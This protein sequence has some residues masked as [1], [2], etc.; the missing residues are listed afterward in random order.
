MHIRTIAVAL[1]SVFC[2]SAFA[3]GVADTSESRASAVVCANVFDAKTGKLTGKTTLIVEQGRIKA[4]ES[5]RAVPAGMAAIDLEGMTCLPG[6]I[7]MHTHITGETSPRG[8]EEGFRLNPADYALRG[9]VYARRTLLAGFT[10]VRNLGDGGNVS[11]ALR[12]AIDQGYV[13]GPRIFTAGKSLATTGGHADPTNGRNWELSGDPGPKEGVV[14]SAEEGRKAVRQ[15]YKDG[16]DLIKITATG[17]VLSYAKNG[18]NPQFTVEEIQSITATAHDYGLRVAAHAHGDEGMRRAILGGVDSIEHGTYMSDETIALMIRK[19]TWY[20]P[21]L[22]AGAFVAEK[23]KAPGYYP[24]IV[25]PKA[26]AIGPK[27]ADTF[28][29]AWKAGVKIAFGTDAAVYPHGQNAH[30]FVLMV[31]AGMPPAA[32]LQ[33]ATL[34]AADLLDQSADLGSLEAGKFA[35]IVAVAGNPLTDIGLMEKIDFVMKNGKVYKGREPA[36]ADP[37]Q[38]QSGERDQP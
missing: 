3:A 32:A 7:D 9:T 2:A 10:T 20:V 27:I 19:G 30:E 13:D 31:N 23:A 15:R 33:A 24:E 16:A 35:D 37:A 17:G 26:L 36:A 1:T 25:R 18:Q 11:I 8:Y 34:R 6:L 4:V 5:G 21:T 29:R 38:A 12:N 14:N 22:M 28:A